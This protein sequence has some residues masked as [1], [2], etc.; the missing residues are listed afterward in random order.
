MNL[1]YILAG[2]VRRYIPA[3]I[4]F[5]AMKLRGQGNCSEQ[6]PDD[7]FRERYAY[8]C[9]SGISLDGRHVVEIGSGRYARMALRLLKV[10]AR[11]VTLVDFYAM[12]LNHPD[13]RDQLRDDCRSLGLNW[14]DVLTRVQIICGDILNL[15]PQMIGEPA[16]LVMSSAV[17]EHVRDP[18]AILSRC[19]DWL[20]PG[21][22]TLHM[23]DLRDHNFHFRYPFEMLTYSDETWD[24][25]LNM[26]GG[27]Y[28]NRWRAHDHLMALA[29]AGFE[30]ITY[31]SILADAPDLRAIRR[32]LNRRFGQLPDTV[33]SIQMI[34][35]YG[36][37][38]RQAAP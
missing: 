31:E 28:V 4:L 17:L 6:L 35:L 21:G 3:P 13:Q 26:R 7:S 8:M 33:L 9:Q 29:N 34:Y 20:C 38:P 27:F 14:D 32:R 12:P 24:R 18:Q 36:R 37:K 1:Y 25:W 10:G 2:V 23:V 19:H 22:V 16:D 30:L 15:S 11:R 5:T